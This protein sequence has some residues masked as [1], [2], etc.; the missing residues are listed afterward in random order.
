MSELN[1]L[2]QCCEL[3][4][5]NGF[6]TGHAENHVALMKELMWQTR[7]LKER[8]RMAKEKSRQSTWVSVD[9]RLPEEGQSIL[10]HSLKYGMQNVSI[11]LDVRGY[12][13]WQEVTHWMSIPEL[14]EENGD[15][16]NAE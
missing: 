14:P 9:E 16:D 8:Y 13:T 15:H 3:V 6:S 11:T 10:A 5:K 7:E 2:E 12:M 1:E 4:M